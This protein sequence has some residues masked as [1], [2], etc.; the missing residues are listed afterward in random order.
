MKHRINGKIAI[1]TLFILQIIFSI[2][3]IAYG[4]A[5]LPESPSIGH[6]AETS[7][8]IFTGRVIDINLVENYTYY[9][10]E[11]YEYIKNPQNTTTFTL[12]IMGGLTGYT[13]PNEASFEQDQEYLVFVIPEKTRYIVA[14]GDYGKNYYPRYLPRPLTTS[15][16]FTTQKTPYYSKT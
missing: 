1:S 16:T 5:P 10:F 2:P 14:Y 9:Q 12:Q 13:K 6:L 7:D 11:T 4:V 15:D 3:I 8:I